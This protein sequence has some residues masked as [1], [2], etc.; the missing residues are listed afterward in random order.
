MDLKRYRAGEREQVRIGSVLEMLPAD[1]SLRTLEIGSRDCYMTQMLAERYAQV[2]ALDLE[3]PQIDMANVLAMQGNLLNLPLKDNSV[4]LAVCTEVLEHIPSEHLQQACDELLR[5]SSKYVLVGVP[6]KQDLRVNATY[7]SCC[8]KENPPTGHLNTF[9]T[10]RLEQLFAA[11]NVKEC[12]YV[13][14]GDYK[15]NAFTYWLYGKCKFPFGSYQ[16][17]EVCVHCGAKLTRP[18]INPLQRLIACV[19]KVVEIAQNRLFK[20]RKVIWIHI[21]FEKKEG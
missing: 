4:N 8:A 2:I 1:V 6:Y 19:G 9:D 5:V 3:K 13:L 21:L 7:C 18:K 12:V 11:A 20:S 17:E 10:A 15:T 14:P 16:Q